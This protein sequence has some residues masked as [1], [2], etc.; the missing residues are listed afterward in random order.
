VR[1]PSN[2]EYY[3]K[4]KDLVSNAERL[5]SN[6]GNHTSRVDAIL[7]AIPE[8]AA[9][10]R[11]ATEAERTQ[12]QETVKDQYLAVMF[13]INSDKKHYDALVQDIEN[14]YTR[15]SDTYPTSLS[16]AYDYIVNYRTNKNTNTEI[17]E[18]GVAFYT[19][20]YDDNSAR[21]RGGRGH[22][23]DRGSGGRGRGCGG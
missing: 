6:I 12:A 16:A 5:G 11:E 19:R 22:G 18:G 23:G 1:L 7:Q 3:D 9:G 21:G 14:E 13:L 17:D 10:G 4:F 8:I 20:D 15:G 2:N